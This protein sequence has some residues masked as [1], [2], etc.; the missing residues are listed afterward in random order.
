MK[1][2]LAIIAGKISYSLA[3]KIGKSGTALPGK[4]A[5]TVDKNI[6]SKLG[7]ICNRIILIT[8]TNGKTTTNN[9]S[10]HIFS[11]KYD[12]IASNL[13]GSNMIQGIITPLLLNSNKK[14]EWGIFE[15][16]EGSIPEVTK[17]ITPDY[18]LITNFFRDQLH[19]YGEVENTIK[20]VHDAINNDKAKLI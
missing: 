19:R 7:K 17:Y 6:L 13:T 12:K 2:K 16:D 1:D 20:L 8:G 10:N 14:Y 4:V 3:K 9:L 15:V 18:L 5:I 11:G